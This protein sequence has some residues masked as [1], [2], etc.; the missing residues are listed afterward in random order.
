MICA[1]TQETTSIGGYPSEHPTVKVIREANEARDIELAKTNAE[2]KLKALSDAYAL[3]AA[4]LRS[5]KERRAFLP[6]TVRTRI[7]TATE[8]QYQAVGYKKQAAD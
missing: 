2:N 1:D 3:L 7:A 4:D 5:A 6:E 8:R